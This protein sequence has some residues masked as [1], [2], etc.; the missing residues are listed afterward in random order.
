MSKVI[1]AGDASGTGTFTISAPNGNTDR[2]LSLPDE[3]GTVLTDRVIGVNASAPDDSVVVDASGNVG[4]G[5]SLPAYVLDVQNN[6]GIL[7]GFQLKNTATG[8]V[9]YGGSYTDFRIQSD[10]ANFVITQVGGSGYLY[11][12]AGSINIRQTSN[13]PMTFHT[14]NTERLRINSGGDLLAGTTTA[15]ATNGFS[16][17]VLGSGGSMMLRVDRTTD[18]TA[19]QFRRSQT[20]VGSINV[21]ASS[22]SYVTSSDYRLK[23]DVQ[24][25]ANPV[26]RLKQLKPVNFAWKVDGSRVDGFLAHEAQEVVSEAVT[27]EKDAVELVD[28]KD[29]DGNVTGQ[30]ER[31]VYQGIDQSKLVPLLTAALQE[32]LAKIEDLTARVSA[33]E[34][35]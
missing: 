19:M 1:I 15:N 11:G 16:A 14:N 21:T 25:V 23:E 5:T 27:G 28:I 6:S 31:P 2:V 13:A 32:A 17:F 4:V 29:E 35:A 20:I 3:A 12:G 24:P 33:L 22:T 26:D 8:D 30:E 34:A 7:G 18:G 9:S 10:S